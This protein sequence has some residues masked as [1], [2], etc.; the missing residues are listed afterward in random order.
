[1]LFEDDIV[2]MVLKSIISALSAGMMAWAL[3]NFR[4]SFKKLM[5][6]LSVFMLYIALVSLVMIHFLGWQGSLRFFIF[7]ISVPGFFVTYFMTDRK[8]PAQMVFT[9]AAQID[10]ACILNV[11]VTLLTGAFDWSKWLDLAFRIILGVAIIA[12]ECRFLRR[13]FLRLANALRG[14]WLTIALIPVAFIVLRMAITTYPKNYAEN[15]PAVVYYYLSVVATALV[16]IIAFQSL[17]KSRHLLAAQLEKENIEQQ[18]VNQKRF[19]EEKLSSEEEL[20]AIRHDMKGHLVTLSA[21]LAEGNTAEAEEYLNQLTG[22]TQELQSRL[23]CADP[24]MDA[25]L[26]VFSSRFRDSGVP[27]TCR[28]GVNDDTLPGMEVCLIL[29]NALENA[30]E[31]SLQMPEEE[32]AVKVQAA[33]RKKQLLIRI[34]N[35]FDGVL[36]EHD[37]LPVTTK[38][39]TGHGYGLSNIRSAIQR[40]GGEMMY[41]VEGGHFVLDIRLPLREETN[42]GKRVPLL[43]AEDPFPEN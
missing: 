39:E 41:R 14:S 13:P 35:R 3:I 42:S 10:V 24:N 9:Y 31:A 8:D 32:R 19:Y 20:R 30:L 21:L 16:Y 6:I 34:S 2:Y 23:F 25:V 18:L 5:A 12:L 11:T 1:M 38:I 7:T 28:V 22:Q 15:P 40:L 33:V 29:N 17:S 37:G 4:Y 27:F 43:M 36:L 26:R